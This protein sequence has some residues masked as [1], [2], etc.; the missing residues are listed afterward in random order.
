MDHRSFVFSVKTPSHKAGRLFW[1]LFT[2]SF[3]CIRLSQF[4]GRGLQPCA[5][6]SCEVVG[7]YLYWPIP[8]LM[9]LGHHLWLLLD[10]VSS[11]RSLCC[12]RKYKGETGRPLKVRLQEHQ[13]SV[14]HGEVEKSGVADHIWREKGEHR[15][16]WEQVEIIDT[17]G[18]FVNLKNQHVRLSTKIFWAA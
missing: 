10:V 2:T 16:V 6:G 18:N 8:Y 12:G 1:V 4:W 15:L 17:I 11:R 9:S 14:T 5:Q 7:Y 3:S 13:K